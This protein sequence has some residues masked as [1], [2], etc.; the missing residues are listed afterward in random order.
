MRTARPGPALVQSG[1]WRCAQRVEA[2]LE[3]LVSQ[4]SSWEHLCVQ[5][6][7]LGYLSGRHK[8][9]HRN[10]RL[11]FYYDLDK[12]QTRSV[13]RHIRKMEFHISKVDELYEGY[14]IQCRLRD[15]ASNMQRAF[16][17]CPP[18]RA[19]RESLQE[20]GRSLQECT[21]VGR[22]GRPAGWA[23]PGGSPAGGSVS[24]PAG[25]CPAGSVRAPRGLA[26]GRA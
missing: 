19:S 11:A 24:L 10:S 17:R 20:L 18:S 16:S 26:R 22:G 3:A 9:T 21:E 14:C 23:R 7:E 8:D 1:S 12:K 2:C 4:D 25:L 13:E 15:G 6:A 5:Q